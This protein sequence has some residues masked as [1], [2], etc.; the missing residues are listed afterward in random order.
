LASSVRPAG[1]P[2]LARKRRSSS[3]TRRGDVRDPS[4]V[5][6]FGLTIA[7]GTFAPPAPP[8][9]E[10]LI[11]ATG[12][13]AMLRTARRVFPLVAGGGIWM[14]AA[15]PCA[16]E[17]HERGELR[18]VY[19]REAPQ[20]SRP[21]VTCAVTVSPLLRELVARAIAHGALDGRIAAE[22]R[23]ALVL[24][25][26]LA[27]LRPAHLSIPLPGPGLA[28]TVADRL[29][30]D[31]SLVAGTAELARGAGCSV[32]TLERAF[33]LEVG[34]GVAAWQR[35]LRLFLALGRL[36]LGEPVT[37]AAF[38]AGYAG[39]SAFI[40]AFRREF[41]ASPRRFMFDRG[42]MPPDPPAADSRRSPR[43]GLGRA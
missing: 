18:I 43:A 36:A 12:A 28:R 20:S 29:L 23:I 2:A 26:E 7:A 40:A 27:A 42:A 22:R 30:A 35:R 32:R 16:I 4:I 39:V 31:P 21:A 1:A 15:E 33:A 11:V 8:G 25:D 24:L 6:T 13:R 14:R 5:R 34:I 41:G 3:Q 19:V 38:D 10:R 37:G 9:W 17:L